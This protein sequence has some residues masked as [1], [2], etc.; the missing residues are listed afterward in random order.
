MDS[1]WFEKQFIFKSKVLRVYDGDTI[2]VDIDLCFNIK[3]KSSV[4]VAGIDTP[5][6]RTRNKG[7]KKLGYEAKARMKELCG[8]T[9]WL[10]SIDGGKVDKYGRVLANLYT[11]NG[12][13]IGATLIKEGHAVGYDGSKKTHVWA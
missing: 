3:M 1:P 2:T 7:E 4:R 12:E 11:V 5:E 6:I 10:E 9:V 13:D 8:K